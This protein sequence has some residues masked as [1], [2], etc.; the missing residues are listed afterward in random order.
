MSI[1][2]ENNFDL[3]R[4]LAAIQV[5]I[6]HAGAHLQIHYS[7]TTDLILELI[8][9]FPGVPVFFTISGFLILWSYE[10]NKKQWVKFYY[11]RMLR[12]YPALLVC[13]L[14]TV[15]VL[16]AFGI[17][18]TNQLLSK[19]IF[20]WLMSQATF[21]QFYTPDVLR[22]FGVGNPN[23]S[24]WT[25][26]LEL[27]FY[28]II[29]VLYYLF[30]HSTRALIQYLMLILVMGISIG[31]YVWASALP[32]EELLSKCMSIFVLPYLYNFIF[33]MII[34]KYWAHL[35]KKIEGKGWYWLAFYL[36]Y[37]LVFSSWAQLYTP[38]YWPNL[39]GFIANLMLAITVV[40]IAYT[41]TSF[42]NRLLNG[43]DFSYGI[44]IYHMLMVNIFVQLGCI[45]R[46]EY[47]L[48]A[49]GLTLVLAVC[50]WFF[51]ER[52]ALK[53]KY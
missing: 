39:W 12:I 25:I 43:W 13:L 33:G 41:S 46:Y 34:Y 53:W 32:Q 52:V 18:N 9:F 36:L 26:S 40:S 29:P 19:N 11:N 45:E 6:L 31:L 42:S 2:K 8:K 15:C 16:L 51:V 49:F 47:L 28:A 38:D 3:I 7:N 4:L 44:Y 27:Q 50:S 14:L 22:S 24:L 17:V 23:G 10:R 30:F 37:S 20:F 5:M 48:L 35:K 1:S 21:L